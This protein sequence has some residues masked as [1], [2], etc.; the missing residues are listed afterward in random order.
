MTARAVVSSV[1][2]SLAVVA[3]A[4]GGCTSARDTLGTS[5]SPCFKAL[6]VARDAVRDRGSFAGVRVLSA[7]ALGHDVSPAPAGLLAG[8]GNDVCVVSYKGSYRLDQVARPRGGPPPGGVGAFAIVVVS[9][10]QNKLL[11][12]FVRST[13]PLRFGHPV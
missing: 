8:A 10:P 11:G 7:V 9:K 4:V 6:A 2:V 5:V 1:L 13:Q 12:T 3:G